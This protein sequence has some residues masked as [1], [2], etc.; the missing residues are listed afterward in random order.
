MKILHVIS[1][2]NGGIYSYVRSKY[3][4]LT[5]AAIYSDIMAFEEPDEVKRKEIEKYS[6][7]YFV[8]NNP[9]KNGVREFVS[10]VKSI[11]DS[12]DYD[13]I[14]CHQNGHRALPFYLVGKLISSKIP[15]IIH[16]HNVQETHSR[17]KKLRS[18][19]TR[20]I[21][22]VI[23]STINVERT[24]C[25]DIATDHLYLPYRKKSVD[26]L[27]NSIDEQY[28]DQTDSK[29][30][31]NE[32]RQ[33]MR[34]HSETFVIGQV[35]R[36]DENKNHSF[37]INLAHDL[38]KTGYNFKWIFIGDGAK[39][40][41]LEDLVKKLNLES[42]VLFLGRQEDIHKFY[43]LMD[44]V[45]HPSFSEGF[46]IVPVE[47]QAAERPVLLSDTVPREVDLELGLTHFL[48]LD[49]VDEWSSKVIH[50]G[51][52]CDSVNVSDLL[53]RMKLNEKNLTHKK[54]A[55]VYIDY[56]KKIVKSHD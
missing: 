48:S 50:L 1:S 16:I 25:S 44:M 47:A 21:D 43:Y 9:K 35:G 2:Y 40:A 30:L 24:S 34:I 41:A 52:N 22:R 15:F 7:N 33:K 14:H 11:I 51:L 38:K 42:D 32:L 12:N 10:S 37:T 19:L 56:L 3:P 28:F 23:N 20:A 27:P 17:D 53:I 29:K 49:N 46:G 8:L 6:G 5:E 39:R 54:A 31:R 4:Y 36:L 45:I 55:Q 26:I 18:M 13:V